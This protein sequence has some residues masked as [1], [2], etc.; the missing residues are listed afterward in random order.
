MITQGAKTYRWTV[1]GDPW[2]PSETGQVGGRSK[3]WERA[4]EIES[5]AALQRMKLLVPIALPVRLHLSFRMAQRSPGRPIWH[6]T[7]P[8]V[9]RLVAFTI[10]AIMA[11]GWFTVDGLL[12][13]VH[14]MKG[15]TTRGEMRGCDVHLLVETTTTRPPPP[16]PRPE[17]P[18]SFHAPRNTVIL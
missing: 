11:A 2:C 9:D 15:Y 4:V 18:A 17:L 6:D 5:R 7:F 3:K 12:I 10:P 8:P 1:L 16:P 14:G 13:D